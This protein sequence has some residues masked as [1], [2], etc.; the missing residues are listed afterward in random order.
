MREAHRLLDEDAKDGAG[1]DAL[2]VGVWKGG[3]E[4]LKVARKW[5]D[6]DWVE[7]LLDMTAGEEPPYP[8]RFLYQAQEIAGGPAGDAGTLEKL[9]ALEYYG[10]REEKFKTRGMDEAEERIASLVRI[11]KKDDRLDPALFRLVRFFYEEGA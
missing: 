6:Q 9:L 3:G 10:S 4:I 8:S 7:E 5:D 11:S 2:A 1:R